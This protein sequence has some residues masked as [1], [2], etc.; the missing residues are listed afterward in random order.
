MESSV[1]LSNRIF[2]HM[3]VDLPVLLLGMDYIFYNAFEFDTYKNIIRILAFSLLIIGGSIRRRRITKIQLALLLFI[4]VELVFQG[5][6]ALNMAAA[7]LFAWCTTHDIRDISK[8][9]CKINFWLLGLACLFLMTGILDMKTYAVGARIRGTLGFVNP[10]AAALFYISIVYLFIISR[11]HLKWW[12]LGLAFAYNLFIFSITDSRTV[13]LAVSLFLLLIPFFKFRKF[14]AV[15]AL[16]AKGSIGLLWIGSALSMLFIDSLRSLDVL[17]S[18]RISYFT[19]LIQR[20]E[21]ENYL[22]G[23][24]DFNGIV[25]DNF[26]YI[27][28]FQYGVLFY[29]FAAILFLRITFCCVRNQQFTFLAFLLSV[30]F[31]GLME[32]SF[33]RPEIL[34]ALLVWKAVFDP[35]SLEKRE[36]LS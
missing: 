11:E 26:Y 32:S 15:F 24:T 13:F 20:A 8:R 33:I 19:Q 14:T 3:T 4:A 36:E 1:K 27:F 12:H 5:A 25:V 21:I 30:S 34:F 18:F 28:L 17:L 2:D 10:N 16:L 22:L 23:G 35:L 9:V 6:P 7:F 31:M 29:A